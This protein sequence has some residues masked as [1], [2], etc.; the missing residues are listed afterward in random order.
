MLV[1]SV[2]NHKQHPKVSELSAI[3]IRSGRNVARLPWPNGWANLWIHDWHII[4]TIESSYYGRICLITS[5]IVTQQTTV[6]WVTTCNFTI[7]KE[8][9]SRH[10]IFSDANKGRDKYLTLRGNRTQETRRK[11]SLLTCGHDHW[12]QCGFLELF[13]V[14]TGGISVSGCFSPSRGLSLNGPNPSQDWTFSTLMGSSRSL[15]GLKNWL[16]WQ[17]LGTFQ[18]ENEPKN[19]RLSFPCCL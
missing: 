13:E 10:S 7:A 11:K 17:F 14:I 18:N 6:C 1:Y 4:V 2:Q 19:K 8:S 15:F 9:L 12:T 5:D 3:R 16:R